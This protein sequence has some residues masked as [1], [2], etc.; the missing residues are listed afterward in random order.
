MMKKIRD[1][2]VGLLAAA[3]IGMAGCDN[4]LPQLTNPPSEYQGMKVVGIHIPTKGD[5]NSIEMVPGASYEFE[6]LSARKVQVSGPFEYC[7]EPLDY[8][9]ATGNCSACCD[10]RYG[11]VTL[12]R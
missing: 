11:S 8:W 6:E 5:I 4:D 7:I 12:K 3:S 9:I 2:L 1:G 10:T